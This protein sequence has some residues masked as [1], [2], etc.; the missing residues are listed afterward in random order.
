VFACGTVLIAGFVRL[1]CHCLLPIHL[2]A[3]VL[4]VALIFF[5][6]FFIRYFLHLHFKCY[7][8][9]PLYPLPTPCSPTHPLPLLGPGV[10]TKRPP[11]DWE[12]IFTN[13]KSDRGLISIYIKNSRSWTPENQITPLKNG[14]ES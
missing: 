13:P 2:V 14:T 12:R 11:T 3:A 6:Q 5:F 1:K 4:M 10:K 9:S 8:E 7:P